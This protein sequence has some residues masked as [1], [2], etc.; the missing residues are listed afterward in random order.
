MSS[1][2]FAS[3]QRKRLTT[4]RSL[5]IGNAVYVHEDAVTPY[6]LEAFAAF[7]NLKAIQHRPCYEMGAFRFPAEPFQYRPLEAL[8]L[9]V[10]DLMCE[11]P[12]APPEQFISTKVKSLTLREN[13][14]WLLYSDVHS[15]RRGGRSRDYFDNLCHH[16]KGIKQLNL[17]PILIHDQSISDLSDPE[18]PGDKSRTWITQRNLPDVRTLNMRFDMAHKFMVKDVASLVSCCDAVS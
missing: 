16:F 18:H 9:C 5:I 13:N 3:S 7:P 11:T 2:L 17:C 10:P 12:F 15:E 6:Y 1:E 8:D 14:W 4:C